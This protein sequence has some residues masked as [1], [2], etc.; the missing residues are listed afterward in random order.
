MSSFLEANDLEGASV[1]VVSREEGVV[2]VKALGSFEEDRVSL[3]ASSSKVM[4]AGVLMH[5]ADQG[6]LDVD[7]PVSTYLGDWGS[8]RRT[9]AWRRC[10]P[11]ARAWSG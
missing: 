11:T 1:V 3:I 8:T 4:S 2:H 10:Y 5:L 7:A 6:L 9:S